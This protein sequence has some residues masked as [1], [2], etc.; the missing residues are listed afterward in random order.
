[1]QHKID[2]DRNRMKHNVQ[3]IFKKSQNRKINGR[4]KFLT[5]EMLKRERRRPSY[6]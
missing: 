5:T 1:M 2:I 6:H 3:C 4:R